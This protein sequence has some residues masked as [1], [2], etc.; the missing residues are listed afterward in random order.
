MLQMAKIELEIISDIDKY[1]FVKKETRGGI[2]Y[3][4]KRYSKEN[5]KYMKSY[6]PNKRS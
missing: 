6:D 2:L 1:L 3:M 5:N 4:V